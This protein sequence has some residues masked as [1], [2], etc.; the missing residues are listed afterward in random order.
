MTEIDPNSLNSSKEN[1]YENESKYRGKIFTESNSP[2]IFSGMNSPILSKKFNSSIMFGAS[3]STIL[4]NRMNSTKRYNNLSKLN[5]FYDEPSTIFTPLKKSNTKKKS[6]KFQNKEL[7]LLT[8]EITKSFNNSS[9]TQFSLIKS[10]SLSDSDSNLNSNLSSNSNS[11][12]NSVL[13]SPNARKSTNE[14]NLSPK[15]EIENSNDTDNIDDTGTMNLIP[16]NSSNK[17]LFSSQISI[18][19]PNEDNE[20]YFSQNII[21]NTDRTDDSNQII[22]ERNKNSNDEIVYSNDFSMIETD[23]KMEALLNHKRMLEKRKSV[24]V[25]KE[26]LK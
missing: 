13:I 25:L 24:L 26:Q 21:T 3:D 17:S 11:N 9:D 18:Y 14:I 7:K 10:N 8:D 16:D 15:S 12:S 23:I 22:K 5:T 2:N 1:I 4:P 20:E 6:I 19:N